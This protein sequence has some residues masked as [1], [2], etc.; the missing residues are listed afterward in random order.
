MTDILELKQPHDFDGARA[1]GEWVFAERV[2][3]RTATGAGV[4]IPD[5]SQIPI[6]VASS[7]GDGVKAK[8]GQ[9]I[10]V[11]SRLLFVDP[12]A[13]LNEEGRGFAIIHCTSIVAILRMPTIDDGIRVVPAS[14]TI[15]GALQ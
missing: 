5:S 11:G 15:A 1:L 12:K 14:A 6:W 8:L 9:E 3:H 7:V 4:I 2:G 10:P 13:L